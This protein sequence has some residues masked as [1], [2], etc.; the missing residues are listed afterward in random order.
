[1]KPVKIISTALL[2]L[3]VFVLDVQAQQTAG[4]P[5]EK[6]TMRIGIH[7]GVQTS[8]LRYNVY[9]YA[10]EF[11]ASVERSVVSGISLGLPIDDAFRLQVDIGWW[12]QPWTASHDGDPKIGIIRN[13]RSLLEF[14]VLLQYRFRK[15]PIP[16]YFAAGPVISLVTDAEKSYT[17]SYTGFTER[18]G[19]RTSRRGF[20]E[21]TLHM[22][23]VG[24]A[25]VEVQFTALLSMQMAVRF[26]QP[27]G[28]TVDEEGF[29]LRE[30]SI[31]RARLGLLFAL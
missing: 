24:E 22:G 11:Q 9:P 2:L 20:E 29:T 28:S 1:V 13:D 27:L 21:E 23:I 26:M 4:Q 12:S 31:W 14:P 25:G 30:L 19:W 17:V 7:S 5:D 16:L 18:D 10:G 8:L 15:L 3:F 6:P